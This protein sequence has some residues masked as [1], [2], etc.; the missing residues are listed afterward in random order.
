MPQAEAAEWLN[1]QFGTTFSK[2]SRQNLEVVPTFVGLRHRGFRS[3]LEGGGLR[4]SPDQEQGA[5]TW[6]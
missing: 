4:P 1:T 3:I 2:L 6:N 5:E